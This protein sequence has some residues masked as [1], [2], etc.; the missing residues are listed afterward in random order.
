ME[1]AKNKLAEELKQIEEKERI[2]KERFVNKEKKRLSQVSRDLKSKEQRLVDQKQSFEQ[3]LKAGTI[4]M[5]EVISGGGPVESIS[6]G[7]KDE[8]RA[9]HFSCC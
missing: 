2:E 1:S 6:C 9:R 8:Y 7:K 3:Q 4:T 5:E